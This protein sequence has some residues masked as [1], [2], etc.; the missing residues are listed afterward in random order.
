MF[1]LWIFQW[2]VGDFLFPVSKAAAHLGPK[3][4]WCLRAA[5]CAEA[6]WLKTLLK[7]SSCCQMWLLQVSETLHAVGMHPSL[8]WAETPLSMAAPCWLTSPTTLLLEGAGQSCSLSH[9]RRIICTSTTLWAF[10]KRSWVCPKWIQGFSCCPS[11]WQGFGDAAPGRKHSQTDGRPVPNPEPCSSRH[12][13]IICLWTH[14]SGQCSP[15]EMCLFYLQNTQPESWD[16]A[17]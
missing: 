8:I 7:T 17:L 12:M 9:F 14:T 5:H 10:Q 2:A 1:T 13:A 16:L 15:S 11:G 6:C 4:V 3:L